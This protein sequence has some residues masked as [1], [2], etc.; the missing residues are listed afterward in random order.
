M[1]EVIRKIHAV[2]KDYRNH[3][4][5]YITPEH[6]AT[7]ANQFGDH[8]EFVLNEILEILPKVYISRN[9]AKE[10]IKQH[11]DAYIN[12]YKYTNVSTFLSDTEFLNMQ[13]P[14][15]S[16]PAILILLEEVLNEA[17]D[18]SYLRYITYP[19]INY[20]YFDDILASGSTVGNHILT[21]LH[22]Q[23]THGRANHEK[24][25]NNEI[26]LSIS[27]FCKHTWGFSFQKYRIINK[28]G[29]KTERKI[30]WYWNYEIQNHAKFN[31]QQLNIA[32]PV[33]GDN[34]TINTYFASLTATKYDDY[35]FREVNTPINEHFFTNKENRIKFE[36][37]LVERGI[38]IIGMIKGEVKPNI[39]PLGL[40]N[41]SYKILG[42]GT[43]FFTWRNI[44]NNSPLVYWWEVPGHDWIPLFS[45]ANR[46]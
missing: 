19:K 7:W 33:K 5:I 25:S 35:A 46:G 11:I 29:D 44:P 12:L 9:K 13:L 1:E 41:P 14:H 6:I 20:I 22:Q 28:F 18:E 40:I 23:D 21:W 39:R 4:D 32:K 31:N 26:K 27:L 2:I 3:D 45:V 8:N 16:Q 36:N 38:E 34:I 30:N 43:H 24:I 15:K 37:I 10:Y 42:L 17:Y